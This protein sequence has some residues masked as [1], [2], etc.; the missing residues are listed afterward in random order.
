MNTKLNQ[1][2]E[3]LEIEIESLMNSI[4]NCFSVSEETKLQKA[5]YNLNKQKNKIKK[6]LERHEQN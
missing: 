3:R 2:L 5:L 1:R 4:D 6:K